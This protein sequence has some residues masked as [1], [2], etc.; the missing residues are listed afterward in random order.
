MA[1][2]RARFDGRVFVPDEPV[3]LPA[4]SEVEIPVPSPP[5][6]PPEAVGKPPLME[7]LEELEKLPANPDWPADGAMQHDHYLYGTPKR[8]NP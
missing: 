6:K 8:E 3:D 1:T 7:L 2:V 5:P 4:G